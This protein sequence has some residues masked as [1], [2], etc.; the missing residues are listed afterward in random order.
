MVIT[1][2]QIIGQSQDIQKI[3]EVIR[4]VSCVDLN[5]LITGE[6][7]VGK[8]LVARSLHYFSPRSSK[9]FVKVNSAALPSELMESELF[10]Y[11]KG[12]FTG[13]ERRKTGMFEHAAQ[14]SLFLDEIG[15]LPM[16]LQS[17][18]LQV[19]QDRN[20]YRVGGQREID[21]QARIIAATN[22]NLE[23]ITQHGHFRDD[24]YY[25]LSTITIHIP[26]LR[27]RKEDIPVL[28]EHFI[29]KI[30]EQN[31]HLEMQVPRSLM[32]TFM[33][34]HWPGNA[35]ELENY[36]NSLSILGN[37]QEVEKEILQSLQKPEKENSL[38]KNPG[39]E[40]FQMLKEP[41]LDLNHFPSLK[42]V[43]DQAVR[44]VEREVIAN[45]LHQTNWNRSQT[46]RILK[47]SYRALLYKI[48]ELELKPP[49]N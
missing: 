40:N 24:L 44:K 30:L 1:K 38:P 41:E 13:A 12:A 26:P 37:Y 25:R 34:Y 11:E 23:A 9:P 6:S 33:Q 20:Y 18:L 48:K 17:K 7:G 49:Y 21:V 36:L 2:P 47:I 19:L 43:R 39:H 22:Q 35:R 14:G 42:E 28:V 32:E 27:D 15:E 8:E 46:A 4:K 45:V 31:P 29:H 5:V 16:R 10:G 3:L